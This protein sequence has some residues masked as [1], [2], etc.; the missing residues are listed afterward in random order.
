MSD[1]GD[2]TARREAKY[3][4]IANHDKF[5]DVMQVMAKKIPDKLS[6]LEKAMKKLGDTEI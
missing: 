2:K 1:W 5:N 4:D 3:D 6:T